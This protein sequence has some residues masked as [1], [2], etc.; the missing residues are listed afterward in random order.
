MKINL[1]GQRNILGGG[2][3]FSSFADALRRFS[4]FNKTIKEWDITNQSSLIE[5]VSQTTEEDINIWFTASNSSM[6]FFKG[7]NILWAIFESDLLPRKYIEALS[8]G[9]LV[10]TPSNW[11]KKILV[12]NGLPEEKIDVIPEGVNQYSFHP[13]EKN[14]NESGFY[15]FL[16]VGKYEQRKGYDQLFQAFRKVFSTTPEVE[17][18]IKADFFADEER[19]RNELKN[20]VEGIGLKNIKIIEGAIDTN[21]LL[22]LYSYADGFVL[23]SR[24]EGWGLTLLEAIACGLPCAAVNYSGQTEYLSR[25]D[26]LYLPIKHKIIPISDF[27]FERCWPSDSGIYGNWA[28]AD[29]NDLADQMLDMVKNQLK[30]NE[31]ALKASAIVRSEFNWSKAVDAAIGSL[32]RSKIL[33]RPKFSISIP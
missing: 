33:A 11:G 5:A 3:H 6:P 31:C 8:K 27:I 21:D 13:F 18:L 19:A 14:V 16:A 17:L 22:A 29:V 9:D 32:M 26:N 12:A 2:V 1:F 15:R 28:E 4:V 7:K 30:W 23:P 20:Q 10:W 25:I 24:A